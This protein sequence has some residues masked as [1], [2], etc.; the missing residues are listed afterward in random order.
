[1]DDAVPQ[2]VLYSVSVDTN[3]GAGEFLNTRPTAWIQH[4]RTFISS[5][6]WKKHLRAK[7][8]QSH[9]DVKNEVQV[10]LRGQDPTFYLQGF[11]KR[12]SC[13]DN[14]LDREGDY[15]EK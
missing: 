14:C 11:V 2:W 8:F 5:P 6:T 7:R 13:L 9:D 3:D 15:V 4:L 12:I 1:M 10:W